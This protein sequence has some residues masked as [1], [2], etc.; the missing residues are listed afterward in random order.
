M[1]SGIYR[2]QFPSGH[3]YIGSSKDY[4][5]RC[6]R[7]QNSMRR[8]EHDSPRVQHVFNKFG[9]MPIYGLLIECRVDALVENEQRLLDEHV[10]HPMCL[11]LSRCAEA[12]ARGVKHPPCTE[13]KKQMLRRKMLGR[14]FS[15][16]HRRLIS[17]AK[18]GTYHPGSHTPEA[19]AKRA[20]ANRGKS[21]SESAKV[22]IAAKLL[23]H[24]PAFSKAVILVNTGR[25][26]ESAMRAERELGVQAVGRAC[27][28]GYSAGKMPSGEP[29]HWVFA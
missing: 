28:K 2:L 17:A 18:R 29:M 1:K 14:K 23:G 6:R 12:P 19:N 20:A 4:V 26:F 21:V 10:G 24:K 11:N 9:E 13:E 3:Y 27:R 5:A 15:D 22:K 25:V 16:E 7:H 8:G